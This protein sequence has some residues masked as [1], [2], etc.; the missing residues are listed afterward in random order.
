MKQFHLINIRK[1]VDGKYVIAQI[2]DSDYNFFTTLT[3]DVKIIKETDEGPIVK[4]PA[5]KLVMGSV[6]DLDR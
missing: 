3:R 6:L 4:F 1:T 5:Q 2:C